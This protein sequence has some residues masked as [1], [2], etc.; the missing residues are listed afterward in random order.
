ME[1]NPASAHSLLHAAFTPVWQVCEPVIRR[2]IGSRTVSLAYKNECPRGGTMKL[3]YWIVAACAALTLTACN[4]DE[5]A[6]PSPIPTEGVT[7][8]MIAAAEGDEW[9]TYGRDYGEQRFSPL[10]QISDGNVGELGRNV[11]M[12]VVD[13]GCR[14]PGEVDRKAGPNLHRRGVRHVEAWRVLIGMNQLEVVPH[15]SPPVAHA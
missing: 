12:A 1:L 8:A 14:H 4:R 3:S 5:R 9:L 2:V 10:R 15:S 11:R 13:R 7:D 6:E